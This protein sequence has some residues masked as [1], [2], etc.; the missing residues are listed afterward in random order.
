[1]RHQK[2]VLLFGDLCKN[3]LLINDFV[4][5]NHPP[6]NFFQSC[7][8]KKK[9]ESVWNFKI[10]KVGQLITM[11]KYFSQLSIKIHLMVK[12]LYKTEN[13]KL[14]AYRLMKITERTTYKAFD[15]LRLLF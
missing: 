10:S 13:S 1:M 8:Q 6:V 11:K 5:L 14:K 2:V 9:D 7:N 3:V 4:G 12:G 15:L